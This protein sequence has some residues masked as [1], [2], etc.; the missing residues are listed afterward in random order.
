MNTIILTSKDVHTL[1]PWDVA[2]TK[3][4]DASGIEHPE[5]YMWK[6]IKG[7]YYPQL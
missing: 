2:K 7:I 5:R 6:E 1:V 3:Q 4:H